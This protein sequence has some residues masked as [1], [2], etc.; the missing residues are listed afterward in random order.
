[1]ILYRCG[2]CVTIFENYTSAS[3]ISRGVQTDSFLKQH[4]LQKTSDTTQTIFLKYFWIFLHFFFKIYDCKLTYILIFLFLVGVQ[5]DNVKN[6]V[7][8]FENS[9]S[10]SAISR[11][12]RQTDR[13]TDSVNGYTFGSDTDVTIFFSNFF[14]FEKNIL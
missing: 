6:R 3:A 11:G 1:M 7:T 8:I 13:Q 9:T 5:T 12:Y 4:I 14:F 10:A 2:K